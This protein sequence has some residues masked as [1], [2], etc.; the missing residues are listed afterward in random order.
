MI[1]SK[2]AEKDFEKNPTPFHDKYTQQPG[3]EGNFLNLIKSI[4]GKPTA[5]IV[6]GES[7]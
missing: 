1:I 5:N 2:D 6:K 7:L 3:M 4:Y